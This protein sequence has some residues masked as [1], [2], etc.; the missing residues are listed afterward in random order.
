MNGCYA[1]SNIK[2]IQF[3]NSINTFTQAEAI[4]IEH[5]GYS[6]KKINNLDLSSFDTA[7]TKDMHYMFKNAQATIGYARTQADANKFNNTSNK[8]SGLTFTVK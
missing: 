4:S 1:V 6:A 8:P 5:N 3:N 2:S 7:N